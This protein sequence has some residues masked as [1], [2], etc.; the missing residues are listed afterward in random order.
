MTKRQLFIVAFA[1]ILIIIKF[2]LL[3][4]IEWQNEKVDSLVVKTRQLAKVAPLIDSKDQLAS[5]Q[6]KLAGASDNL[7]KRFPGFNAN[8]NLRVKTQRDVETVV[9]EIGV[10]LEVFDWLAEIDSEQTSLKQVQFKIDVRG[11]LKQ[12]V[13]FHWQLYNKIPSLVLRDYELRTFTQRGKRTA[14]LSVILD[15]YYVSK[16]GD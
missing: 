4:V 2:I 6:G 12:L 11:E 13:N 3:P 16:E 8:E 10:N 15:A 5:M 1:G 9:K 14:E 7:N